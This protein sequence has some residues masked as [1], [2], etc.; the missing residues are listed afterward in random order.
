[1]IHLELIKIFLHDH[2]DPVQLQHLI[3]PNILDFF[4]FEVLSQY[5]EQWK[6]LELLANNYNGLLMFSVVVFVEAD[7]F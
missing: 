4:V 1:M 2:V 3:M 5:I 6:M 7:Q